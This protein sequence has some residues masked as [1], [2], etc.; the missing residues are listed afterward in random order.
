M[1]PKIKIVGTDNYE[2]K[3][4]HNIVL[5]HGANGKVY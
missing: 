4:D 2:Y 1:R 3:I 5:G